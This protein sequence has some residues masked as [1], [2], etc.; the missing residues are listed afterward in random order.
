MANPEINP[1][2][3]T[4]SDITIEKFK[5][6]DKMSLMPQ[7]IEINI[8]QSLF[9]PAISAEIAIND[10]IGLFTNYPLTGEELVTITYKQNS[11][12]SA[13]L[14]V[15]K[16][17]KFII[18][19]IRNISVS[20]RARSTLFT[21]DLVSPFFLQNT[22]KYVS[23]YYNDLV[24]KSASD[25]YDE[26]VA[27]DTQILYNIYKPLN[28][29]PTR[30]VRDLIIPN[31]RP[32]QGI[33]WLA[34]QAIAA[35]P[36][37]YFLYLFYEDLDSFNFLTIQSLIEKGLQQRSNL[38]DKKYRYISDNIIAIKDPTD[39]PD[40]KLRLITNII[41]NKRNSSIEKIIGGYF[42]NEL[43]E[44]NMLTK[45]Y[46]STPTELSEQDRDAQFS[47]E[48]W[49][50]NT[51]DYINYVKNPRTTN[52][53]F[54]N[55]IRYIINN[56]P[57][58]AAKA[59]EEN[60]AFK[61]KFG[62]TAKYLNALNQ[63]D[64]TITVPANMEFKVGDVIWV[65]IPENHGFNDVSFDIYISGLFIVVEVKQVLASGYQAATSLRIYKDGALNSLLADSEYNV[66]TPIISS[67]G[68]KILGTI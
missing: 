12:S 57:E 10:Q 26:Y 60:P 39:D 51:P 2:Q 29:E 9:E 35:D 61:Q 18:K 20:D 66:S 63:I 37:N 44:I 3:V 36:A 55:R 68:N 25:L 31:L 45:S 64:L 17:L 13:T 38:R 15:E 8:Y 23:H 27:A 1:L 19:S 4:V 42:Q 56:Y 52:S 53:E 58:Y 41:V 16:T 48:R 6:K 24:E 28:T 47:L 33:Q 22:R 30:K 62:N 49:P 46:N 32:Y 43:F 65:D 54:S 59:G 21:I 5:G 50:L 11:I 14:N 34:K 7:F 67:S 40:E